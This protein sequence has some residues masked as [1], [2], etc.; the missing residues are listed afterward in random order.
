M[1]D[2]VL[3]ARQDEVNVLKFVGRIRFQICSAVESF[4]KKI[5][6]EKLLFPIVIDLIET[7]SIDST[8]LGLLAQIAI[9]STNEFHHKPTVLVS[10]YDILR[11]L[12]CMSFARIFNILQ[13]DGSPSGAFQEIK[14][15]RTDEKDMRDRILT[16]H[17][18][19]MSLSAE[20][21]TKFETV[22]KMLEKEPL[23]KP[24]S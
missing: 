7:K 1:E 5:H 6:D 19:L 23:G 15:L 21:R 20:N 18:T 9:Q 22:V 12:R 10:C 2:Q 8:V 17:R 11:V 14:P 24:D 4:L 3:F 16:A 13:G